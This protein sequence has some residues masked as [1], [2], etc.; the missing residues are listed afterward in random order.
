M[1]G[2]WTQYKLMW[3][4]MICL[5]TLDGCA[6]SGIPI[7]PAE[8]LPITE[9]ATVSGIYA[10]SIGAEPLGR[11]MQ[12]AR[13][14]LQV[15][16]WPG[17]QSSGEVLW[18]FACLVECKPGWDGQVTRYIAGPGRT[19]TWMRMSQFVEY[20]RQNGWVQVTGAAVS[21]AESIGSAVSMMSGAI[22]GFM[23]VP[24]MIEPTQPAKPITLDI[25]QTP[26]L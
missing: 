12:N 19:M 21:A 22:T 7:G 10:V 17:A 20:L 8:I 11:I 15:V 26:V 13:T 23:V 3:L 9:T 16:I 5:F 14:G 18:N 25:Y 2:K 24:V 6:G 1:N 4:L